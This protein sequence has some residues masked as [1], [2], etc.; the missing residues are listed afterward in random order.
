MD[1]GHTIQ[2]HRSVLSLRCPGLLDVLDDAASL[3]G[4]NAPNAIEIESTNADLFAA[5][6]QCAHHLEKLPI[7]FNLERDGKCLLQ[8][9]DCFGHAKLKMH[10]EAEFVESNL[11][12]PK[13]AIGFLLFADAHSCAL[14]KE[15]TTGA[16]F[17]CGIPKSKDW[18]ALKESGLFFELFEQ[19]FADDDACDGVP[20]SESPKNVL[21]QGVGSGR[22]QEN[23]HQSVGGG[24]G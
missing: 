10:I 3:D 16:S 12:T 4:N 7:D 14:L 18:E 2:A 11:L 8:L 24:R 15:G 19:K 21:C 22:H 9:A 17:A 6:I 13:I 1:S 5:L 23:A 20:V